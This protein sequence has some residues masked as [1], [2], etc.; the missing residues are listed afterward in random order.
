MTFKKAKSH[1]DNQYYSALS[2]EVLTP[3]LKL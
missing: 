1:E 2:I 3:A